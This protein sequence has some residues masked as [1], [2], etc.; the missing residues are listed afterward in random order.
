MASKV[1][2]TGQEK[3]PGMKQTKIPTI[4]AKAI[5]MKGFERKRMEFGAKEQGARS[6]LEILMKNNKLEH[7]EVDGVEV[8]MKATEVKALVKIHEDEQMD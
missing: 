8:I 4:H 6:E 7:Y 3:L 1:K 2:A 5:E